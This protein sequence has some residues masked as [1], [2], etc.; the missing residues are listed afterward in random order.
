MLVTTIGAHF[1]AHYVLLICIDYYD[2]PLI[3]TKTEEKAQNRRYQYT[4]NQ[5]GWNPGI[6][7]AHLCRAFSGISEITTPGVVLD[8]PKARRCQIDVKLAKGN[9]QGVP[10]V[11]ARYNMEH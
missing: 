4:Q 10:D 7:E 11:S 1:L 8:Q 6:V 9:I 2:V 5:R 3:Y